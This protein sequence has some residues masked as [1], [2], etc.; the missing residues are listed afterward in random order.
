MVTF[1]SSIWVS[2]NHG[3]KQLTV[4]KNTLAYFLEDQGESKVLLDRQDIFFDNNKGTKTK[5]RKTFCDS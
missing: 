1:R 3:V 2:S 5:E 4:L